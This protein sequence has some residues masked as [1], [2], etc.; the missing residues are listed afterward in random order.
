MHH[1]LLRLPSVIAMPN[2]SLSIPG[3]TGTCLDAYFDDYA[4]GTIAWVLGTI[5]KLD[6]QPAPG[7]AIIPLGTGKMRPRLVLKGQ[8]NLGT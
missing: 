7:V 1:G 2:P 4:D 5:K 3:L 6:L 8:Q